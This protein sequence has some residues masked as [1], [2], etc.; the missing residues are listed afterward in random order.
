M[1]LRALET[2][3]SRGHDTL[4]SFSPECIALLSKVAPAK[5]SVIHGLEVI[6]DAVV[7]Y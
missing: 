2:H 3:T 6:R 1:A 5:V 4:V 7:T